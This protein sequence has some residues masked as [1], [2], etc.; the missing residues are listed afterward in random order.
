M[1]EIVKNISNAFGASGFEEEVRQV[2]RDY[3]K[4]FA[5]TRTDKIGNLYLNYKDSDMDRPFHILLD[6]HQD[7]VGF[8][9]HAVRPNG[10]LEFIPMGGWVTSN[11]PAHLMIIQTRS[12]KKIKGI[13]ASTP[14]HFMTEADRKKPLD[15]DDL[16]IDVGACSAEEV[17][18]MGIEIG[19]PVVPDVTFETMR[20]G[21]V[22]MGK[23]FD[24]RIGCACLLDTMAEFAKDY[25]KAAFDLTGALSVQEEVG[26]RGAK[27]VANQVPADLAI[28]FEGAPADDTFT[29]EY[30]IQ[31]GL[32]RGPMLRHIDAGMIT[33]A[34]F[35]NYAIEMAEKHGIAIQRSVRK[36]GS[37][38]GAIYHL[39]QKGI[40]TIVI[41]IP[42]R[43]A[44]THYGYVAREDYEQAKNLAVAILRDMNQSTFE[45]L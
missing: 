12:G 18:E 15:I 45:A 32:G 29:P 6:A 21:A 35:I 3:T 44:H 31:T 19:N 14:P 25:E 30:K 8:M 20:D 1:S 2:A 7:E 4:D 41:S 27:I 11:I 36:G 10:M 22:F 34:G 9:I 40:P 26:V 24:C 23:G 16:V 37:T 39:A 28:V 17:A 42:V 5:D 13:T 43:Y 38:N 33:H